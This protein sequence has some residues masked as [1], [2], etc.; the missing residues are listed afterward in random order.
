MNVHVFIGYA[1]SQALSRTYQ[2]ERL[3]SKDGAAIGI[4]A[5]LADWSATIPPTGD[6]DEILDPRQTMNYGREIWSENDDFGN[7]YGVQGRGNVRIKNER[8]ACDPR[9][10]R[11]AQDCLKA[12]DICGFDFDAIQ[13][14]AETNIEKFDESALDATTR[15]KMVDIPLPPE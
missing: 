1:D 6:G 8:Y 13:N 14:Y 5:D 9:L 3:V 7:Y 12:A 15:E 10:R 11:A 2:N 4:G